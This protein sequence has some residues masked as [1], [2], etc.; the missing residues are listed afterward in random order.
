[1]NDFSTVIDLYRASS[2]PLFDGRSF[3]ATVPLDVNIKHLI[4]SLSLSNQACG[5]VQEVEIDGESIEDDELKKILNYVGNS[6][7]Y[8]V[9]TP[10]NGAERFYKTLDDFLSANTLKKG[11]IPK[12]YYIVSEDFYSLDSVKPHAIKKIEI[13]CSIII[14]LSEIAH[15]HDTKSE[16]INYRLVFVKNSD[17]KSISVVLETC[18]TSKMLSI[19][20]IDNAV[21]KSLI[22]NDTSAIPHYAEK[23]GIFR[24]TIVEY[25][26]D[27]KCSF[28]DLICNWHDFL[29]LFENN[30]STYMSGFSFHKARKAVAMAETDFAE[31]ISKLIT[32][33]TSKILSIPV[34]I[35]ASIS[36][37]KLES[38]YEVG[39]IL[40]GVILTSCILYMVLLNQNNQLLHINHAKNIAFKPFIANNTNYPEELNDEIKTALK[41][42]SISYIKCQKTINFFMFLSWVPSLVA[43]IIFALKLP[44]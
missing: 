3:S 18:L 38:I 17:A 15:F 8:T 23:I 24:N 20:C 10:K 40:S 29:K 16:S 21:L 31:K 41:E 34:T 42:L 43:M 37:L 32:D 28:E 22:T 5:Y 6:I 2:K 19:E 4:Q 27:N 9:I 14:S 39:L 1:M 33:L 30:L 44:F 26:I 35:V 7:S 12:H 11:R 13:I 25:V 36:I